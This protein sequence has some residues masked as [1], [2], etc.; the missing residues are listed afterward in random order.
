MRELKF[1]A[2]RID[3]NKWVYGYFIKTPITTE[4][5][6]DGQFLDSG[7]H[8]RYCIVQNG[9]A[10]E[11]DI[12]TI[13]QYTEKKDKNGK[14]VYEGD[15]IKEVFKASEIYEEEEDKI[16]FSSIK[17]SE[18]CCAFVDNDDEIHFCDL[19]FNKLEV[20]SNIHENPELLKKNHE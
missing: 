5:D 11:I 1:R 2:K 8:G 16:Y 13:G 14:E 20:V 18:K 17:W 6:C 15:I 10:H 3:N 7:G 4:F 9:V 12:N 19:D